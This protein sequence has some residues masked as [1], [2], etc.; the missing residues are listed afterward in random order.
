[1]VLVRA[2]LIVHAL[3]AIAQAGAM[4]HLA[5]VTLGFLRGSR[6]KLRLGRVYALTAGTL[7]LVTVGVGLLIYPTYRYQVAGLYLYRYQPWAANLFDVKEAAGLFAV[8][9]ALGLLVL[10]RRLDVTDKPAVP[11]FAL[12]A[13]GLWVLDAFCVVAGLLI[14]AQ[15][16]V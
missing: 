8:P 10:G 13:L 4:T 14:T 6:H 15:R 11:A 9:L 7:H 3:F 5:L 12:C 16:G 2:L 1:M